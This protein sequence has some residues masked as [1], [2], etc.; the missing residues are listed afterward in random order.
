[1][2]NFDFA[3]V[4]ISGNTLIVNSL[5]NYKDLEKRYKDL[6]KNL[7]DENQDTLKNA[8]A[9][10][11]IREENVSFLNKDELVEFFNRIAIREG[12]EI[13]A[14]VAVAATVSRG[15]PTEMAT[16]TTE[17]QEA[18][19]SKYIVKIAETVDFKQKHDGEIIES[20]VNGQIAVIND[21]EKSRIWDIDI[22]LVGGES[23]DLKEKKFHIPDLEPQ[24]SWAKDYAIKI[25]PEDKPPIVITEKVDTFPETEEESNI[26]VLSEEGKV[27]EV[28]FVI[29]MENTSDSTVALVELAKIIPEDFKDFK[30]SDE[31]KGKAKKD[32]VEGVDAIVWKVEEL[33]A[34]ETAELKLKTKVE[35][36]EI[37]T[38]TSGELKI[39]YMLEAGTYSGLKPEFIDGLSEEIF[40]VDRDERDDQPDM[41]DCQFIFENR[42]EFPMTLQKFQFISGDENTEF[43]VVAVEPNAV[44][45]PK[46][47]YV[48]ETWDLESEDEPSFS[49]IVEYTVIPRTEERLSM[50]S[51]LQALDLQILA[52]EG[53]KDFSKNVLKSY[54]AEALDAT[55]IAT[56]RGDAPIDIIK[57]EDT[58]PTDFRNPEK[59]ELEI[60]FDI[61][62][63]KKPVPVEDFSLS[64]EPDLGPDDIS[65]E[66]KMIIEVRD[67][68]ENTGAMIDQSTINVKY[69]LNAVRP[70]KDARYDAPVL[71]QGYTKPVG[72]ILEAYIEP[73]PITVVHE[74]RRTR[75]G[76]S[77]RP[78]VEK[79]EYSILL[80]YINKGDSTKTNIKISDFVPINFKIL[81]SNME[82]ESTSK[83]DGTLL[84]WTIEE[85][86][87]GQEV[88][89][90]Y[91][92]HG[93]GADY[94]LKHIEARAFK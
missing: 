74:R 4:E 53:I 1:R 49:E 78:G 43:E 27:Q 94:T 3:D 22:E 85:I 92:I 25:T 13:G 79:D 11:R 10:K 69:P 66:R 93:E 70:A 83:D 45:N 56:I 68:L 67:V 6:T 54:R 87:P 82:Y 73:E 15:I 8:F 33:E 64:F 18:I 21:A 2:W 29:T 91:S 50:S 44:V 23:T 31:S 57:L 35:P 65:A 5:I 37:K 12:V 86:Q 62:G 19:E 84:T 90:T 41:W 88:E 9:K 59:S 52:V 34:G 14:P 63:Q 17:G 47:E 7:N 71:F 76:K 51:T 40:Y 20:T 55:I 46:T 16:P 28:N 81:E 30:V 32:D 58:I 77:V 26:F 89:I 48:S 60:S 75:I 72:G 39:K 36:S 42:S 24:E 38:L 61:K 80:L